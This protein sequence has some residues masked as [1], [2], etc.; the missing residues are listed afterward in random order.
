MVL[1]G[2]GT[3][4]DE[5]SASP[6]RDNSLKP[7]LIVAVQTGVHACHTCGGWGGE[8]AQPQLPARPQPAA[9]RAQSHHCCPRRPLRGTDPDPDLWRFQANAAAPG[10]RRAT[11]RPGAGGGMEPLPSG[12]LPQGQRWAPTRPRPALTGRTP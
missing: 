8:G 4:T 7:R 9:L 12:P 10:A 5:G 11:G 6:Q 3:L 2:T 1:H